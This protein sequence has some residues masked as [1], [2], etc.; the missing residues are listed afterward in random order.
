MFDER[1]QRAAGD[2][3][4]LLGALV[5]GIVAVPLI[6]LAGITWHIAGDA[7]ADTDAARDQ[8]VLAEA[9][10]R[11]PIEVLRALGIERSAAAVHMNGMEGGAMPWLPGHV[12]A[13]QAVDR[14]I[15]SFR[16][17]LD[18][19]GGDLDDTFRLAFDE[20]VS[21]PSLR[22][23]VETE[24]DGGRG[25]A[26]ADA[27][28]T[29]RGYDSVIDAFVSA[30]DRAAL[31]IDDPQL[32]MAATLA[33]LAA[34]QSA[35][36]V[37]LT[38]AALLAAG[39]DGVVDEDELSPLV[40]RVGELRAGN[41]LI[42]ATALGEHRAAASALAADPR[43]QRLP[44]LVDEAIGTGRIDVDELLASAPGGAET[45]AYAAFER[46]S[47][48]SSRRGPTSSSRRPAT[49]SAATRRWPPSRWA[50]PGPASSPRSP[51]P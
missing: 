9:A 49:A 47:R 17:Q 40:I 43:V 38:Q 10:T 51:W 3:T 33:A 25:A 6:G 34:V 42:D 19:Q 5:A 30:R 2:G 24:H 31:T 13:Q 14:A 26:R 32:R 28:A 23:A 29:A 50:P 44:E 39:T 46:A 7:A 37:D 45:S 1:D 27:T 41:D 20:S 48:S 12:E 16:A 18:S 35:A 4:S 8:V 22:T 11:G 15:A 21:L 36:A